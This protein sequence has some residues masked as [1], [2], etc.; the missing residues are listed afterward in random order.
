MRVRS[1]VSIAVFLVCPVPA[2]AESPDA[3]IYSQTLKFLLDH[4]QPKNF[5][6]WSKTIDP[7]AMTTPRVPRHEPMLQFS[8]E[9]RGLRKDMEK[10]LTTPESGNAA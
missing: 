2:H 3:V 10:R 5:A 7:V 9:L 8:R 6:V 1:L 4:D